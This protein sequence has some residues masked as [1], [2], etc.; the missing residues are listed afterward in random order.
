MESVSSRLSLRASPALV[1]AATPGRLAAMSHWSCHGH[2]TEALTPGSFMAQGRLGDFKEKNPKWEKA[3]AWTPQ[4]VPVPRGCWHHPSQGCQ[5]V[6]ALLSQASPASQGL[7]VPG[8][9][10]PW[11]GYSH[12][13]TAPKFC[14][15][16]SHGYLGFLWRFGNTL[17]KHLPPFDTTATFPKTKEGQAAVQGG[18]NTPEQ[19][20]TK[21]WHT[22]GTVEFLP[23]ALCTLNL[24]QP[25]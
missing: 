15:E 5:A 21:Y 23:V 22:W 1:A 6:G 16:T 9:Q 10:V 4:W 19:W 12:S 2:C 17:W 11:R 7:G 18:S 3:G 8:L 14:W 24:L 20:M 13:K 25:N